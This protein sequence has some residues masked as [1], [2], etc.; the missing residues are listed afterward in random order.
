MFAGTNVYNDDILEVIVP[1]TK[2][3]LFIYKCSNKFYTDHINNFINVI[4]GTIVFVNRDKYLIYKHTEKGF[5][6]IKRKRVDIGT[7]HNKGGQSQHRHER[8]YDIVKDYYIKE[9]IEE[10]EKL[11]SNNVWVFGSIDI[12]KKIC[13]EGIKNGSSLDFDENTINDSV[14][15]LNYLKTKETTKEDF[16]FEQIIKLLNVEPNKLEFNE[17]CDHN[18]LE[19]YVIRDDQQNGLNSDSKCIILNKNSKYYSQLHHFKFIG[20]KHNGYF[21][22]DE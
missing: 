3:N 20:I 14:R 19:Y 4:T 10:I 11:N 6:Q 7:R 13:N 22:Y 16:I 18:L 15:W 5:T 2:C 1:K 17:L 12:L 21:N 8:N 9:V